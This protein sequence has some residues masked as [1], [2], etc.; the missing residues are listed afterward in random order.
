MLRSSCTVVA[1]ACVA[2]SCSGHRA[3]AFALCSGCPDLF[4]KTA[5]TKTTPPAASA[6]ADAQP[7]RRVQHARFHERRSRHRLAH[8]AARFS[9]ADASQKALDSNA[10]ADILGQPQRSDLAT[11]MTT[12]DR[13]PTPAARI[14]KLFNQLGAGPSDDLDAVTSFR[15]AALG[16]DTAPP[17]LTIAGPSDRKEAL[18]QQD[19]PDVWW[20]VRFIGGTLLLTAAFSVSGPLLWRTF[21]RLPLPGP[22]RANLRRDLPR[23]PRPQAEGPRHPLTRRQLVG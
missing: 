6:P 17:Q 12:G 3:Q 5:V 8:E 11:T 21:A 20:I 14:D 7:R 13:P 9:V 10:A 4:A 23:L 19:M 15:R 1:V 16:R 2:L 18:G 22:P